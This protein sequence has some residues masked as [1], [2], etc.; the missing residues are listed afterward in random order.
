MHA[1]RYKY[2]PYGPIDEV[3]PY[4]IRRT[5]ENSA[6][7]GSPGVQEERALVTEAPGAERRMLE[8]YYFVTRKFLPKEIW[9]S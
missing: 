6:I 4:L 5:Q 2:V 9:G 7:L 3:M 8:F 1:G